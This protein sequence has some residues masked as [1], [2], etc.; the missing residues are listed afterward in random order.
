MGRRR[1]Q[2]N[3]IPQKNNTIEDLVEK[4]ENEYLV[5]TATDQR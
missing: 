3:S 5:L 4:E 1:R 2:G